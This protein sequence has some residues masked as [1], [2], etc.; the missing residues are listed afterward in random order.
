MFGWDFPRESQT[1]NVQFN[2]LGALGTKYQ[3]DVVAIDI[4]RLS[5]TKPII[6]EFKG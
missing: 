1:V 3:D 6:V 4:N 2:F 5:K